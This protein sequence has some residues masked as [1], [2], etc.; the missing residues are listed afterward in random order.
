MRVM[1]LLLPGCCRFGLFCFACQLCMHVL[2]SI[3]PACRLMVLA[4]MS[5][6]WTYT[7]LAWVPNVVEHVAG[8][9]SQDMRDHRCVFPNWA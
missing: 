5:C 7:L 6:F 3:N 1:L 2:L 8:E 4:L 9:S